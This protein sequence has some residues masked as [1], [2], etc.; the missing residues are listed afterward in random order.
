MN[1]TSSEQN[2]K[3]VV[4]P[5]QL[6]AIGNEVRRL[7][8]IQVEEGE[9][10]VE[11]C[12]VT[13]DNLISTS[14]EAI[15]KIEEI[16]KKG[17]AEGDGHYDTFWDNYQN[18]G[19]RTDYGNAF[20]GLSGTNMG[21]WCD[22][23]F[24][25]K[26][27]FNC[28]IAN[29]MFLNSDITQ[30]ASKLKKKDLELNVSGCGQLLQMFMDSSIKDVPYLDCS[31]ANSIYYIFSGSKVETIEGIKLTNKLTNVEKAFHN[32]TNLTRVIFEG[33]IAISGLNLQ[34]S[35]HLDEELQEDG[36]WKINSECPSL[37]SLLNC[38]DDKSQD[39]S[40]TW[41][42]IVCDKHFK[43]I[44]TYLSKELNDAYERGWT[45]EYGY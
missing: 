40:G 26:Y 24:D 11:K 15:G 12:P 7:L 6:N 35:T 8:D 9:N 4:E 1:R 3:Y 2:I 41:K 31:S 34:W 5:E 32:C 28:S 25:P 36:T 44:E 39:T 43:K 20:R 30:L 27:G 10:P 37:K 29:T 16:Y 23:I 21:G 13:I 18:G 33:K 14:S 17:K 22:A 38:L 19:H 45:I 42:V